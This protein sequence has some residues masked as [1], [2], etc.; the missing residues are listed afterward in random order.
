MIH[1][2]AGE[3]ALGTL[4]KTAVPG[5]KFS[6]DDILME[7]P[8]TDGLRSEASWNDRAEYLQRYF[9]IPKSEYLSGKAERDR[10]LNESLSYDEIVLWFEFDLFCQANLLY[11]LDWYAARDLG[12]AR[13]SLICPETFPGRAQFRGLGELREEELESLFPGR[14]EVT[15]D[16]K[17]VAQRAWQSFLSDDPQT[18]EQFLE[19]DSSVLPLLAPALRAHLERFPSTANGLGILGQKTLEILNQQA[20]PFHTLFQ[21]VTT[22]PEIFRHGMGDLQFQAYLDIWT[23]G[24]A[25]LV[26]ENGTIE[27]TAEGR[28]V[29][30][31]QADA[32]ELNGIDLW[33]GGVHLTTGNLWRWDPAGQKLTRNGVR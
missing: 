31:N 27:V 8:V 20:A 13:L 3:S 14:M 30:L 10:I 26:R 23:S 22:T 28:N 18:V 15:P 16:Q 12:T 5:E 33:Y 29:M 11:F 7:G 6:I 1:L 24:P 19:S 32:I 4:K 25:P 17:H 21:R 9:S 2:V